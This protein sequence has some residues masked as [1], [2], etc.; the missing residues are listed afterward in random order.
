MVTVEK[1]TERLLGQSHAAGKGFLVDTKVLMSPLDPIEK[2]KMKGKGMGAGGLSKKNIAASLE[3]SRELLGLKEGEK[4]NVLYA[5]LPDP[6]TQIEE[7]V[8]AFDEHF[9]R[10]ECKEVNLTSVFMK[11]DLVEE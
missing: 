6:V 10:G 5:H 11:R 4:V 8:R 7:S 2:E 1:E 3:K 9:R